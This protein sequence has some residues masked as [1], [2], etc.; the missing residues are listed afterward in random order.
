MTRDEF[1][2]FLNQHNTRF[3]WVGER[4]AQMSP[5]LSRA[6]M[7]EWYSVLQYTTATDAE[8]ASKQLFSDKHP[9]GFDAHPLEIARL[10]RQAKNARQPH[11][12][13]WRYRGG[14]ETFACPHC[15]DTGWVTCWSQL[16]M[17]AVRNGEDLD[18][19]IHRLCAVCCTCAEGDVHARGLNKREPEKVHRYDVRRWCRVAGFRGAERYVLPSADEPEQQDALRVF[20]AAMR[21]EGHEEFAQ[22]GA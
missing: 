1:T 22:Y 20:V 21:P 18:P 14:V 15:E 12:R 6:V 2:K 5:E 16:S 4:F 3:T 19:T 10:A 7:R 9:A 8:A 13:Q 11:S 17:D